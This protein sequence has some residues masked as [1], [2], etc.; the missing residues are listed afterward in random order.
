[1]TPGL[2]ATA[3]RRR[4]R[5]PRDRTRTLTLVVSAAPVPRTRTWWQRLLR[6]IR[7]GPRRART[8]P[9]APAAVLRL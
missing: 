3:P 6:R 5:R 2:P 7:W 1:M 4:R 8:R 9:L